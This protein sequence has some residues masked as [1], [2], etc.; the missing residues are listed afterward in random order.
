MSPLNTPWNDINKQQTAN[1]GNSQN[2]TKTK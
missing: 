1:G 2:I